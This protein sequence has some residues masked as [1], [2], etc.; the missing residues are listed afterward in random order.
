MVIYYCISLIILL[1][2]LMAG[3]V[4][5]LCAFLARDTRIRFNGVLYKNLNEEKYKKILF[6][7]FLN[8][9]ILILC[10]FTVY[11][12]ANTVLSLLIVILGIVFLQQYILRPLK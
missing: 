5:P 6:S 4:H 11:F 7:T 12:K 9:I 1:I 3:I 10:L 2:I 8:F